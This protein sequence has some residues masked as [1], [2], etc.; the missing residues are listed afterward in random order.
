VFVLS[1]PSGAGKDSVRKR[2]MAEFP[3]MH[4]AI[5]ATTR[6][7]RDAEAPGVDHFFLERATFEAKLE[8]GGF[9]EHAAVYHHWYGTPRAQVDE[10]LARGQDV[11]VRVD[12]Q[13]AESIRRVLPEAVGI[14]LAPASLADLEARLRQRGS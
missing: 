4:C 10:P 6:A 8:A 14:F 7:P 1:G 9:L 12:V 13:G 5:T 11:L 3:E 2:L